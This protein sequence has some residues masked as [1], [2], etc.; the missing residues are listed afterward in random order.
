MRTIA[1]AGVG[2]AG[3]LSLSHFLTYLGEDWKVVSIH[4]PET[5]IVGIG[6]STTVNIPRNLFFGAG[7]TLLKDAAELEATYKLGI[8]YT[9]WRKETFFSTIV[10]SAY[11]MHFNNFKLKDFAFGRF[12]KL[13]KD[14]F[15]QISAK[16]E[17]MENKKSHVSVMTDKGEYK[18]DYIIDCRGWPEDY[19]D[20]KISPTGALNHAL[21]HTI[22]EPGNW[23][24]TH[25]VA[26][27]NGWMFGIPLQTRQGWGYLFNDKI[28][29][30]EDAI[31][32]ISERFKT[33]K[34]D[35]NLREFTFKNF[36]AKKFID[37][38]IL[39]NGNRAMFLEPM[40][41]LSGG[42]YCQVC[43]FLFDYIILGRSE[44]ELNNIMFNIAEEIENYIAYAYHG[45]STYDSDFWKDITER[46]TN[47]INNSEKF[48][49]M[50]NEMRQMNRLQK[51]VEN[52]TP[53]SMVNWQDFDRDFGYHYFTE[54]DPL[55]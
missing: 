19:S 36:I 49:N 34:E 6:E 41:A 43:E 47:H 24:Y 25:H 40:E 30:K 13:W 11:G 15:V 53:F 20:Y 14:K 37:G 45:G 28:S 3:I 27:R 44:D 12:E 5:P 16:I 8:K 2:T 52:R 18:F 9:G 31:D 17:S 54:K 51:F 29:S 7:F 46:T 48:Q 23:N 55:K 21:V 32:D 4:D 42:F 1:V 22:H 33:K 38:R 35:L 39:K 50:L 10:P 26:H